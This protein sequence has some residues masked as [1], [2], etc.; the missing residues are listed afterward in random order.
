MFSLADEGVVN[1]AINIDRMTMIHRDHHGVNQ[2]PV[3]NPP[4]ARQPNV[5]GPDLNPAEALI[6][7]AD[8]REASISVISK[9]STPEPD[10]PEGNSPS[11]G[12]RR[13]DFD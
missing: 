6:L 4:S 5:N 2:H 3:L 8:S 7:R 12:I 11:V 10:G 1:S 13:V 9:P